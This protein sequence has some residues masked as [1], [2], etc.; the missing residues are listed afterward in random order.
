V[1]DPGYVPWF[2]I[3]ALLEGQGAQPVLDVGETHAIGATN[4]HTGLSR[5]APEPLG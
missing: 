3:R 1:G 2:E 4:G 5:D